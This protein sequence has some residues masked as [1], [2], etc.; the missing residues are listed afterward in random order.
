MAVGSCVWFDTYCFVCLGILPTRVRHE[1]I[2]SN[3]RFDFWLE[4]VLKQFDCP[5]TT[6]HRYGGQHHNTTNM[7]NNG[8]SSD[9]LCIASKLTTNVYW[10]TWPLHGSDTSS[11]IATLKIFKIDII[12]R[13]HF[14][15]PVI[16]PSIDH[17]AI[18]F[19]ATH[20]LFHHLI[21]KF[22]YQ[23]PTNGISVEH[24]LRIFTY[25]YCMDIWT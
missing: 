24:L 17:W 8:S 6:S 1:F 4:T 7:H 10:K 18:L 21:N 5:T 2:L 3:S 11:F 25:V 16:I 19:I 23:Y 22:M 15:S 12:G 9:H 14:T 13:K 20:H